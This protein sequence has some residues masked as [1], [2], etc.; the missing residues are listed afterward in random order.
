MFFLCVTKV[1]RIFRSLAGGGEV[2]VAKI[3]ESGWLEK[4][5][6]IFCVA[7]L[8]SQTFFCPLVC[9]LCFLPS[10]NPFCCFDSGQMMC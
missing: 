5:L 7:Y 4:L 3:D 6:G 8:G 1:V 10:T 2:Q 9:T